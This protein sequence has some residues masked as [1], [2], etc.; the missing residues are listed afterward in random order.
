M[1][2]LNNI[3]ITKLKK[4]MLAD[5]DPQAK[6]EYGPLIRK[7]KTKADAQSVCSRMGLSSTDTENYI[8]ARS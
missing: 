3:D 7:I 4:E 6:K 2:N 8:K 5:L 1:N